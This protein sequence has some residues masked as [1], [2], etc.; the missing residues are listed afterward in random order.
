MSRSP[1]IQRALELAAQGHATEHIIKAMSR[2]GYLD[3]R[4]HLHGK[5]IGDQLVS[6]RRQNRRG[7]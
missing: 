7:P 5:A 1:L 3:V 2:E 6:A 4:I